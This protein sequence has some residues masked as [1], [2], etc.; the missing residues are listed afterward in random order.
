MKTFYKNE[1][2]FLK[3]FWWILLIVILLILLGSNLTQKIRFENSKDDKF[4]TSLPI[5]LEQI[6]RISAFRSCMG[7]DFSDTFINGDKETNRSMKHY[8]EPLGQYINSNDKV[9]LFA[10]F[11]GKVELIEEGKSAF[12]SQDPRFGG[13]GIILSP[14]SSR[15]WTFSF[16][17]VFPL[18]TLKKGSKV[19]SGDLIG[20]A[21]VMPTGSS[22]DLALWDDL[23]GKNRRSFQNSLLDSIF[24]HMTDEVLGQ[25]SKHGV[26]KDNIIIAKEFRDS[27]PCQNEP[28]KINVTGETEVNFLPSDG[29]NGDMVQLIH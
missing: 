18:K 3:K 22:F 2:P 27:N 19:K 8:V 21:Y 4:I 26:T 9:K 11:D 15:T 1:K 25:F 17:H 23:N 28:A 16:G 14:D 13:M 6:N 20:Y 5:D 24:N 12:A 29:N 7:H 10:P